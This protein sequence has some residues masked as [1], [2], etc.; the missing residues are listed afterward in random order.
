[1]G[2]TNSLDMVSFSF[3]TKLGHYQIIRKSTVALSR[4]AM[5]IKPYSQNFAARAPFR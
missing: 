5:R 3:K 1:V 2:D 4:P